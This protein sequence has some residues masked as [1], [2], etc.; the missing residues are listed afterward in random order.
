MIFLYDQKLQSIILIICSSRHTFIKAWK[1][2]QSCFLILAEVLLDNCHNINPSDI[3]MRYH[4]H[5]SLLHL[6]EDG[7]AFL[8]VEA[9]DHPQSLSM[10]YTKAH[11]IGLDGAHNLVQLIV[12]PLKDGNSREETFLEIN[13]SAC[14]IC[15]TYVCKDAHELMV[16]H[17]KL[18]M[19]LIQN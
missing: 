8:V 4:L 18:N 6:L 5:N 9:P 2:Y 15:H 16:A 7:Y 1:S 13:F 19:N 17:Y 14:D 3:R 10:V 11:W 12:M